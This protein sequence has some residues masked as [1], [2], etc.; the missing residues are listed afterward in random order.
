MKIKFNGIMEKKTRG[1]P[2]CG[3]AKRELVFSTVKSF[4][5]PSGKYQTF[6]VGTEYEVSEKDMNFLLTYKSGKGPAFE[7][8]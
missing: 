4:Y 2:V 7:V 3:R 5:L 1:C 6:R 8:V